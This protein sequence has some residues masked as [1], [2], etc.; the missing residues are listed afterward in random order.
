M[1]RNQEATC[2]VGNLEP[3]VGEELLWEL[4]LQAG[5]VVNVFMPKDKV[6][7]AKQNFGFVEFRSPEDA[8]YAMKI[9]NMVKLFGK[10]IRVNKASQDKRDLDIGANIFVGNLEPDVDE[11]LL[12]DTFSAFGVIIA[13]PKIMRD[14]LSGEHR[15]FGFVNFANFEA[16]DAAI[17]AMDG[18][19]LGGKPINVSYAYKR[20]S[21][22]ERHGSMAERLLAAQSRHNLD[23]S[24]PN[25]MFASVTTPGAPPPPGAGGPPPPPPPGMG[26]PPPP[27]PGFGGAP[28]PPPPGMGGPPGMPPPPPPPGMGGPPPPPPPGMGMG[29][30]RPPPGG[31]PPP[32]FRPPPPPGFGGPG[33]SGPPG[34]FG[35]PGGRPP[36]PPFP[37]Q[38]R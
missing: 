16:S 30:M 28:P 17:A 2:Y 23:M 1:D 35:G 21:A 14:P 15:G 38:F 25:T 3:Q 8:E 11:K 20:D 33:M 27:P 26:M 6:T 24:K 37:P 12:Y 18:Q 36:P 31:G 10:P 5:P 4:F 19:Y 9:M 34:G 22:G 29:M 32:G 7:G 13:T